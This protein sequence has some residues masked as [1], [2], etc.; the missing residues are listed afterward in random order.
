M[1]EM[2]SGRF[3]DK[4][5]QAGYE[6]RFAQLTEAIR[7]APSP[8]AIMG[9]LQKGLLDVYEVEMA[10][11]FLVD[12]VKQQLVSWIVL[13]GTV[14]HKIRVPIDKTSIVGHAAATRSAVAVNNA[15]DREELGRID[16]QLQF[17]SFWDAKAGSRTRQVL[18]VPILFERS[19]MG[20][21]QLMNRCDGADFTPG[22]VRRITDLAEILGT[23]FHKLQR[24]A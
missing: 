15:Y 10:S 20:V 22:D 23:T 14:L 19:L 18:A 9:S 3:A 24:P 17:D 21:I 11:V 7:S 12:A 16:A 1:E 4:T 8:S 5:E 2:H 6:Q 13:P